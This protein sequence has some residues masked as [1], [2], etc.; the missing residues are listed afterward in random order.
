MHNENLL[1]FNKINKTKKSLPEQSCDEAHFFLSSAL[2]CDCCLDRIDL[3]HPAVIVPSRE[4]ARFT[5]G[6]DGTDFGLDSISG[7]CK[8]F[9]LFGR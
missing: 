4:K 5:I 7:T 6:E 9:E 1:K 3:P 8:K 2:S